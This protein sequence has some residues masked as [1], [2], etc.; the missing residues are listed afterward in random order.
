M[1]PWRYGGVLGKLDLVSL[2]LSRSVI[3]NIWELQRLKN[4]RTLI[5]LDV[6]P[7]GGDVNFFTMLRA[8]PVKQVVLSEGAHEEKYIEDLRASG[9]EVVLVP[10]GESW[11]GEE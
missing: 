11:A 8:L 5:L 10:P 2:D 6:E 7:V 1:T 9:K 4:L 3:N